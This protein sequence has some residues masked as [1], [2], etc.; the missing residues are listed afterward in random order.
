M[1]ARLRSLRRARPMLIQSSLTVT[2]APA[3]RALYARMPFVNLTLPP[4]TTG[5]DAPA[6]NVCVQPWP[7]DRVRWATH[8]Q[9][10]RLLTLLGRRSTHLLCYAGMCYPLCAQISTALGD[11][12]F[13]THNCA[14]SSSALA[15]GT[16]RAIYVSSLCA[17][18][19]HAP[20]SLTRAPYP[21]IPVTDRN[22]AGPHL[23]IHVHGFRPVRCSLRLPDA[24]LEPH[25]ARC[26]RCKP[27]P[28][29]QIRVVGDRD[30]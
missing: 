12:S 20:A 15:T 18:S 17:T 6:S 10:T 19:R 7:P 3:H 9:R 25:A 26:R 16:S 14:I 2:L 21:L 8:G 1:A 4:R 5:S 23:R 22:V 13:N 29:L 30:T 27:A 24:V 28:T 11:V